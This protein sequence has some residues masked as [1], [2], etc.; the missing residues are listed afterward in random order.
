MA[1]IARLVAQVTAG[2]GRRTDELVVIDTRH[3]R[4]RRGAVTGFAHIR[5]RQVRR[6]FA[7]RRGAVV[8]T[9]AIAGD[10]G[11]AERCRCPRRRAVAAAAIRRGDDVIRGF[12]GGRGAVVTAAAGAGDLGVLDAYRRRPGQ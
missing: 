11:V 1:R 9:D 3:R 10:A 2:A 5:C 12:A 7:C 8:T 6:R 4:P